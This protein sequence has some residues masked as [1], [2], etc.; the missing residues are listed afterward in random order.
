MINNSLSIRLYQAIQDA[1]EERLME[2]YHASSMGMCPKAHWMRR[3]GIETLN[4]P[5]GAKILRWQAG[6]NIETAIEPYI[7]SVYKDVVHNE[8][9]TSEELQ[10]TGEFDF[11]DR[12]TKRIIEIKSVHDMAFKEDQGTL[13]LKE[14][15]GNWPNGN[16][17]WALK[18]NP[19]LHHEMQEY[20]YYLLMKEKDIEVVGVDYVYISLSGR[21]CTYVTEIDPA[22]EVASLTTGRLRL[23]KDAWDNQI[24]PRCICHEEDNPLYDGVLKWCDYR[25]GDT[26]CTY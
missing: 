15:I 5:T 7:K 19:Y 10:L 14:Q 22:G 16:K 26:C 21:I 6:H 17:K 18:K 12:D 2:L 25:Q 4:K 1:N 24:A 23:L 13:G 3:K 20:C 8:R 9:F 11:Y